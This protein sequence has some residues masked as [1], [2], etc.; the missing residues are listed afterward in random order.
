MLFKMPERERREFKYKPRYYNPDKLSQQTEKSEEEALR[1]RIHEAY[2]R[3]SKHHRI[4]S[5]R[6][7]VYVAI[8]LLLLVAMSRCL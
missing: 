5:T 7:W 2:Q 3:E 8:L 4:P 6:L 1:S